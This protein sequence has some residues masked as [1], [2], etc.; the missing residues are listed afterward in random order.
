MGLLH[1]LWCS[2]LAREDFQVAA[3]STRQP[4][5]IV[6][7]DRGKQRAEKLFDDAY[8]ARRFYAA[9]LKANKNPKL[10]RAQ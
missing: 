5:I 4:Q 8:L 7:Y 3:I 10:R 6:I 9:K 1:R 2:S